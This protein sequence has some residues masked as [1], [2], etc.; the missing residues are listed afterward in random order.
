MVRVADD[1][2]VDLLAA[3]CAVTWAEASTSAICFDLDGVFLN[4]VDRET[5]IRTEQT[6]RPSDAADRAW[7]QAASEG[8]EP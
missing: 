7:L 4:V 5:L 3:A 1:V 2:M 6:I 8:E